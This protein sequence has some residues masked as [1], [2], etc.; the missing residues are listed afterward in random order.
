MTTEKEEGSRVLEEEVEELINTTIDQS[1]WIQDDYKGLL[2]RM[3]TWVEVQVT[4]I[5]SLDS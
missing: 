1:Y 2:S 4:L 3:W 5:L